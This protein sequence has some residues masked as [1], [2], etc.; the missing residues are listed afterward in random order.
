MVKFSS[1]FIETI[2]RGSDHRTS[3]GK[4]GQNYTK[5]YTCILDY[6]WPS[7][8]SFAL[9]FS[10]RG[11][12]WTSSVP[13]IPATASPDPSGH[14]TTSP[15][16]MCLWVIARGLVILPTDTLSPFI[17]WGIKRRIK[18][19]EQEKGQPDIEINIAYGVLWQL[20]RKR[21]LWGTFEVYISWNVF[22][23]AIF[24]GYEAISVHAHCPD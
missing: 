10:S 2:N 20:T 11:A 13:D 8:Y 1:A 23:H 24:P 3:R 6:L 22:N 15:D 7:I 18:S 12:Y 5:Q 14:T 16:K 19:P 17:V 4:L 21:I 9:W